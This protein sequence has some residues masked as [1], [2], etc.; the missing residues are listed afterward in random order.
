MAEMQ[1]MSGAQGGIPDSASRMF[2]RSEIMEKSKELAELIRGSEEV[3]IFKQ[4]EQQIQ[5][6]Q[7]I[8]S[9]ISQMKKKQK[10]IVAF[11]SMRNK[12]MVSRIEKEIDELQAQIDAIPLVTEY[13][14]SQADLNYLLQF[15]MSAIQDTVSEKINVES[16]T[17]APPSRCD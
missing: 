11:E 2:S 1:N 12:E 5:S 10:E 17:E 7:R 16:G 9:L 15:V 13:Q 4:A 6:H 14:Q 3:Q 8:Q